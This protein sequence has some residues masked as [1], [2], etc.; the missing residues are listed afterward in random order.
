MRSERPVPVLLRG[1]QRGWL[2]CD[3]LAGVTVA[4]FLIP[5]VM[6]YATVA[7]LAPVAGLWAA[8]PALVIY[9]LLG[10]STSLSMGPEATTALMTAVAIG[11]LAG[12][13]PALYAGLASTLALLVG[14]M[15]VAAWLLRLGI[16][17]DLLSR[18]VLMGYMAGVALIMI[19]DQLRRVTGIPVRG[20]A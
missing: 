12:G 4:A 2:R 11:P 17:A 3:A 5:Q 19:A 7:G 20:Q 16:V 15:S 8:L 10:S 6:A 9:A 14:L 13:N 18:P 1:Y